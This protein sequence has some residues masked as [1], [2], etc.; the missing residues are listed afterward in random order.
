MKI[1][2]LFILVLVVGSS[3]CRNNTRKQPQEPTVL[4]IPAFNADSAYHHILTQIEMGPRRMN[5]TAHSK[6]TNWLIGKLQAYGFD[7][8]SQ[9]F[10]AEAYDGEVLNGTNLHGVHNPNVK[11]RVLLCAHYDTRHIADKD[12]AMIDSPIDGADDGASGVA[13]LLEIARLVKEASLPMGLDIVLFDAE[14]HGSNKPGNAYTWGL[15][16]QYWSEQIA[17]SD[18]E[19]KYG[20]LL[21]MVGSKNA[22]FRKE[23]FSTKSAN[24]VVEQIWGLAKR[25]G[26]DK[27]FINETTGF[28]TDDHRFI[29]ERTNIPMVDI[30]NV[31]SNGSF[32]LYHHR[33]ADNINIISKQTIQAVGQV[34]TAQIFNESNMKNE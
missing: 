28:V 33:H 8:T 26:K 9:D 18:Y 30:I 20:I 24:E 23:G 7:V 31:K 5:S 2:H 25:I 6:C 21:D 32:G 17:T 14:D 15:G 19:Y 4:R 27:Y 3:S 34:T 22:T 10:Q 13:I 12:T 11:E 29:I 1:T 16:S